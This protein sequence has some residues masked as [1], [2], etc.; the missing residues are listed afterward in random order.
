MPDNR[1]RKIA[2]AVATFRRP[3]GL[4]QLLRSFEELGPPSPGWSVVDTIVVDNDPE[5]SATTVATAAGA[6]YVC[7]A[8]PGIAAAR[9]RAVTHARDVGAGWIAFV[10][11]DQTV[12]PEWLLELTAMAEESDADAVIGAVRYHHPA[13]SPAWFRGMKVF[14][15]QLVDGPEF[16]QYFTTN[17]LLLRIDPWPVE[18]PLFD[19]RFGLTGGSDHHLG[20]R[21]RRSGR[22]VVFAPEAF[23]D[24]N[25]LPSRIGLRQGVRRLLRNGNVMVRTERA[26]ALEHDE[27]ETAV[28]LRGMAAGVARIG[29]GGV[30]AVR[31]SGSGSRGIASGLKTSVIGVGQIVAAVGGTVGEYDRLPPHA[32][33]LAL[34]GEPERVVANRN[35]VIG[36]A[37]FRRPE[38]LAHLLESIGE[39]ENLD[40]GWTHVDTVVIDNDP[41]RSAERTVRDAGM[42]ISYWC[43]PEPGIAAARNRAVEHARSRGAG[44]IAFVDDDQTVTPRWLC[45]LAAA[46]DRTS[47][48]A[49]IGAVRYHHPASS[50]E[51]FRGLKVFE[52]QLVDGPESDNYFTTN[53]LLLQIDP[54]PVSPP[55]FDLRF[56]LTGGEDHHLGARID[57]AGHRIGFAPAAFADENVLASRVSMRQALRRLL[58]NGNVMVR[59]DR[60]IALEN[61]ESEATA[62]IRGAAAGVVRIPF[63]IVRALRGVPD[64]TRGIAGGA[65]TSVIGAGQIMGAVGG[66]VEEYRR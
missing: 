63:G 62:R 20:A 3:G 45:E 38:G 1:N 18:P 15:D 32:A 65:R 6:T 14:E 28:R 37:S 57:R 39:L 19:L 7:E 16:V 33:G 25:V 35:I 46:A 29:V 64:G 36:V 55:L 26:I 17:N 10:D 8:E 13:S 21:L 5:R 23:A 53:N 27:S 22:K 42:Q 43:E 2:I 49:V 34:Q 48:T 51:W 60:A 4:R 58:R 52:D 30:R 12:T 54:W 56:G 40:G 61:N 47:A 9:N 11:D 50:P 44:W 59:T 31:W 24:E 66:E 41:D